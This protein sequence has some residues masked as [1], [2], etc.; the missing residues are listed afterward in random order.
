[1]PTLAALT[2]VAPSPELPAGGERSGLARMRTWSADGLVGYG[3]ARDDVAA[4][5]TSRASPYLHF[6]CV[7]PLEVTTRPRGRAGGA[8]SVRQVCWRDFFRRLLAAR[9]E[10]ARLDLRPRGTASGTEDEAFA[11]WRTGHTGYPLADAGMR[12]L[13][14]RASC[15]TGCGWSWHRFSPRTST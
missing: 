13:R 5:V 9:P 3:E 12:Q 11:A 4:D 2:S 8:A 15:T 1:M 14:R 6:G 7:S 10:L